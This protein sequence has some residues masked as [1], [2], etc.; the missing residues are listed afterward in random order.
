MTSKA[1]RRSRNTADVICLFSIAHFHS[2]T[3]LSSAIVV[4]EFFE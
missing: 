3:T 4:E 2:S 1:F